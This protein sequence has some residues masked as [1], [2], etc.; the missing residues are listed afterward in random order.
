MNNE[1]KRARDDDN[2]EDDGSP[3]K[4]RKDDSSESGSTTTAEHHYVVPHTSPIFSL[5]SVATLLSDAISHLVSVVALSSSSSL[6]SSNNADD[7]HA[8]TS[9]SASDN[10]NNNNNNDHLA[11]MP[12]VPSS[13]NVAAPRNSPTLRRRRRHEYETSDVDRNQLTSDLMNDDVH[14]QQH[15]DNL[16]FQINNNNTYAEF[17]TNHA[18]DTP[19]AAQHS[20]AFAFQYAVSAPPTDDA[21]RP[22]IAPPADNDD[23]QT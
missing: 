13:E 10:N 23:M 9:D 11:S 17:Q 5:A 2:V 8:S 7:Q 4:S 3:M 21:L 12:S 6:N 20:N 14:H 19:V 1:R 15:L 18:H 16:A 22:S